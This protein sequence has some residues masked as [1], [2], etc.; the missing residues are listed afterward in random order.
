MT[1]C[2]ACHEETFAAGTKHPG[3]VQTNNQSCVLCHPAYGWVGRGQGQ[4]PAD[5]C[6][7]GRTLTSGRIGNFE[8]FIDSVTVNASNQPVVTFHITVDGAPLDLST[9][10]P[11]GFN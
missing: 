10:P 5:Q 11:T 4:S 8:Y 6:H 7:R 2:G 1:A 9:Y 3:G